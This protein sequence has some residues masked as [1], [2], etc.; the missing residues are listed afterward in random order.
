MAAT[1]KA[2]VVSRCQRV[3]WWWFAGIDPSVDR[4]LS[5][6]ERPPSEGG[7][8][9]AQQVH[10]LGELVEILLAGTAVAATELA[11]D[12]G[13]PTSGSKDRRDP[14]EDRREIHSS[15]ER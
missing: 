2:I 13:H 11:D 14:R 8:V 15:T 10:V 5:Q 12:Q 7:Q 1:T 9:L 4:L 6:Q 3:R